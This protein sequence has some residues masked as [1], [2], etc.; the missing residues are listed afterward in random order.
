MDN[1]TKNKLSSL[2][3]L[4]LTGVTGAA[5]VAALSSEPTPPPEIP[6]S[7]TAGN[8]TFSCS[9]GHREIQDANDGH[10][11][12]RKTQLDGDFRFYATFNEFGEV[13]RV[14]NMRSNSLDSVARDSIAF[15]NN[16]NL[17]TNGKGLN[18]KEN[19]SLLSLFNKTKFVEQTVESG[20]KKNSTGQYTLT[21]Q[22]VQYD[23]NPLSEQRIQTTEKWQCKLESFLKLNEMLP[24]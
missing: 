8:A 11:S 20:M 10:L 2:S 7:P 6:N 18:S 14:Q 23:K 13:K 5:L 24:H 3:L 17:D 15:V 4:S 9:D 16:Q 19:I 21:T 22:L 12:T 1:S